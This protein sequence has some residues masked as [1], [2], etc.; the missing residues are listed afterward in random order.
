VAP[1]I[2]A[3][4][5]VSH[6]CVTMVLRHAAI[7]YVALAGRNLAISRPV[8]TSRLGGFLPS[9]GALGN[10]GVGVNRTL[11]IAQRTSWWAHP[12]ARTVPLEW[13]LRVWPRLYPLTR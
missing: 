3:L 13:S 7:L 10:V 12:F 4:E 6:F 1:I 5:D 11:R 8:G 9:R 2:A